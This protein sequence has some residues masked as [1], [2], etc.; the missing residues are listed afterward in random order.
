MTRVPAAAALLL[1]AGCGYNPPART[2]TSAPAYEAA[3]DACHG[4]AVTSV[5]RQNAKR[6]L[7]WFSSPVRRWGQIGDAESA[8]MADKGYGRLR[9]CTADELANARRTGNVV[10]TASGVQCAEPPRRSAT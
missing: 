6:A 1:L 9:W 2:N 7:D 3:L 4:A 10:V 8:C 5:R